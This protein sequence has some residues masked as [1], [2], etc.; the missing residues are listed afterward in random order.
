VNDI[1]PSLVSDRLAELR[2]LQDGI[3]QERRDQ[4]LGREVE[5]LVDEPGV[6]RTHREAPEIDGVITL[7]EHLKEGT[8]ARV[9][10]VGA[11]GPDLD[12]EEVG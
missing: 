8:F 12:A 11:L 2:E 3:T 1:D 4:L 7:P 5:V 9:R 10:I 6:G